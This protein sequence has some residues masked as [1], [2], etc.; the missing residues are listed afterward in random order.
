MV[1]ASWLQ[2]AFGFIYRLNAIT[3]G[4]L[5]TVMAPIHY[6]TDAEII[7][8]ALALVALR[9]VEAARVLWIRDTLHLATVAASVPSS[10]DTTGSYTW[11]VTGPHTS[12]ARIRVVWTANTSVNDRSDTNFAIR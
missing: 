11:T 10:G 6:E 3:A 7:D 5:P 12:Q 4:D 9:P 8:T 2:D 1:V